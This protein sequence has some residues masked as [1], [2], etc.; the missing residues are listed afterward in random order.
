MNICIE[1]ILYQMDVS[2]VMGQLFNTIII[3]IILSHICPQSVTIPMFIVLNYM[4]KYLLPH[5]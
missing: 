3:D 1:R 5:Q 4:L 2:N